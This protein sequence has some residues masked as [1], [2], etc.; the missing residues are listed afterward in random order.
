[1][2]G[3]Y[4]ANL[5]TPVD[6]TLPGMVAGLDLDLDL[7][8]GDTCLKTPPWINSERRAAYFTPHPPLPLI[9]SLDVLKRRKTAGFWISLISGVPLDLAGWPVFLVVVVVRCG[10]ADRC[11]LV[12]FSGWLVI[13]W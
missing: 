3:R 1:M 6:V 5:H 12:R 9:L 4:A 11:R 2:T 7:A 8:L 10:G 13:G